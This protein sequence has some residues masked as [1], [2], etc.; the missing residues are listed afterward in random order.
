MDTITEPDLKNHLHFLR[1]LDHKCDT[2]RKG[3]R[4]SRIKAYISQRLAWLQ[5]QFTVCNRLNVKGVPPC[6]I[7]TKKGERLRETSSLGGG[8]YMR[9][10]LVFF[11][12]NPS[13]EQSH[14]MLQAYQPESFSQR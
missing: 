14:R 12:S 9:G 8:R 2:M 10:A 13:I 6:D 1:V 11:S 7:L 5:A 3:K 4:R